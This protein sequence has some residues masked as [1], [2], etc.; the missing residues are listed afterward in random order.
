MSRNRFDGID[1]LTA[2]VIIVGFIILWMAAFFFTAWIVMLVWGL[3][4]TT[5]FE[6]AKFQT[7]SYGEALIVTLALS[8]LGGFF[9]RS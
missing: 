8:L 2:A 4:G 3:V 9:R 7:I 6:P 5:F 1:G